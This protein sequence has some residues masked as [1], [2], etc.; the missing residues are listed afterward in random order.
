M[1][2]GNSRFSLKYHQLSPTIIHMVK[3][4]KNSVIVDDSSPGS[5]AVTRML[6]I[7]GMGNGERESG[8]KCTAVTPLR[9]QNGG[10]RKTNET[11]CG[12]KILNL[13]LP[14]VCPDDQYVLVWAE[15]EI[16]KTLGKTKHEGGNRIGII[17]IRC[18]CRLV[19]VINLKPTEFHAVIFH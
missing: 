2:V 10:Q 19:N 13:S 4:P 8:N 17:T 16:N 6:L 3:R 5:P 18:N 12:S 15:F 9:I 11:I 14:A 7:S 1:I